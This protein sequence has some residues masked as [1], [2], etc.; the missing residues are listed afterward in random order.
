MR[1]PQQLQAHVPL[2]CLTGK[3][4]H[5]RAPKGQHSL[6]CDLWT[7]KEA[8]RHFQ[9][10]K[11]PCYLILDPNIL[12]STQ[13]QQLGTHCDA[14]A[15]MTAFG[16]H[17]TVPTF[18]ANQASVTPRARTARRAPSWQL[19]SSRIASCIQGFGQCFSNLSSWSLVANVIY[20]KMVTASS[21]ATMCK[22]LS[23][24][25]QEPSDQSLMQYHKWHACS[26]TTQGGYGSK[27][28]PHYAKLVVNIP[29]TIT[30]KPTISKLHT[31][32]WWQY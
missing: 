12:H 23:P 24:H 3:R 19:A 8:N 17:S 1:G 28:A 25:C 27:D 7:A 32:H 11:V 26:R 18:Y 29:A 4:H 13:T 15:P 30:E 31:K 14:K 6:P 5:C 20:E 21:C 9:I 16:Q 22:P 2:W 10:Y